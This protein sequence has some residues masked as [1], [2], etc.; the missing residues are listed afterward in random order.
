MAVHFSLKK[1]VLPTEK[2]TGC[3]FI[4]LVR[5]WGIKSIINGTFITVLYH[6]REF[7]LFC[8]LRDSWPQALAFPLQIRHIP[9]KE[10]YC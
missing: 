1:A 9:S 3:S 6:N 10:W 7:R 4:S 5:L 8:D 2:W